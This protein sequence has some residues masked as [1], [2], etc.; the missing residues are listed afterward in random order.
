MNEQKSL[1]WNRFVQPTNRTQEEANHFIKVRET[2]SV[3]LLLRDIIFQRYITKNDPNTPFTTTR[4]GLFE[5]AATQG[6]YVGPPT[7]VYI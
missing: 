4:D 6:G 2:F 7:D 3:N 5:I 1:I